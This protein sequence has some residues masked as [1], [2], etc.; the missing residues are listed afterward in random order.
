[1]WRDI[2]GIRTEKQSHKNTKEIKWGLLDFSVED[3]LVNSLG[4]EVNKLSSF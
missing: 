2:P 4:F 1:M 3:L